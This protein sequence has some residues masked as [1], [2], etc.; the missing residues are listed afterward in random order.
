MCGIT[1]WIDWEKDLSQEY[2]ILLNMT[3]S[4]TSRGPDSTDFWLTSRAALGHRRLIVI[5]PEGG[6][7][8][9]TRKLGARKYTITYNGE[10][11]NTAELRKE[12]ESRGHIFFTPNSDTETLL[13]AYVEWGA[14]C[15]ERLNGIFA[16]AIWEDY[17][18]NLFLARDRLGVKPLFYTQRGSSFIFGSELK[19]I[20]EHPMVMPEVNA[21]GLAEIFVMGP[22]RTPGHGVFKGVSEVRPGYYLVFNRE[23]MY[24]HPYWTLKSKPHN[25]SL[26]DTAAHVQYLL[27]DTVERQLISDVPLCT[28]LSGGLDSSA[29]TAFAASAFKEKGVQ[30]PLHTYSIDYRDNDNHFKASN[31]QPDADSSWVNYVSDYLGTCHHQIIIDIF[32][33]AEALTKSVE[34][35]D[36]PGM[37]D[38]DSSLY[39]FCREIKKEATVALSGEAADE[40]FG[41]YP[42]FHLQDSQTKGT[43]PWVRSLKERI[44]L[45]S[46]EL[47]KYIKPEEYLSTRYQ[48][49]LAEVPHLPGEEE[50][51][52]RQRELLYLNIEWF[53][54]TLLD[55][56]DRMSMAN[57]L[58]VR[59]PFC[60]HRL[61]EYV[62]NIP[63]HMKY[64]DSKEKGILRRSLKGILPENVLYRRK[65]PY[66]K[67]H[68]PAYLA[69]VRS[70]LMEILED[71]T[72]PLLPL[73]NTKKLHSMLNNKQNMF[74]EP[75]FGQLMADAQYF[76]YL[77]QVD[78]WLRKY[79]VKITI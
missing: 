42:W 44:G 5:D 18:E 6:K 15:L 64:C 10:L 49:T 27:K 63:W 41:G 78:T 74:S 20:L 69:A 37:A 34:A 25:E 55:R 29:L 68:N 8:P 50:D 77:I 23:R 24:T 16:F 53:M 46:P 38:V 4:I 31:Y 17:E 19:A 65:S 72:S 9:M 26:E 67:T 11:Y 73:I 48:E 66:P 14:H 62:W 61:V 79:E 51:E 45:L 71:S 40:I 47:I 21:E 35:R 28:L 54:K 75:W 43:F 22:S 1:G 12:L 76:A 30:E 39:L 7:Q 56:K 33:L 70:W 60:D 13:M 52:A 59:V 32:D 36:L 3:E 58:E 57:G 2:P